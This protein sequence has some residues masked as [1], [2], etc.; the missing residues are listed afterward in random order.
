VT[1]FVIIQLFISTLAFSQLT[2]EA[3]D[4]IPKATPSQKE[5]KAT[6]RFKN[7]G[8]VSITISKIKSTCACL[9]AELKKKIYKPGEKGEIKAELKFGRHKGKFVK[10]IF[11]STIDENGG[12]KLHTLKIGSI[13]PEFARLDRRFHSWKSG[14]KAEAKRYRMTVIHKGPINILKV[15]S[16]NPKWTATFKTI[17]TGREFEIWLT[18]PNTTD[19]SRTA[20]S[21]EVDYPPKKHLVFR[22]VGRVTQPPPPKIEAKGWL[23]KML[24]DDGI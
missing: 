24:K 14:S 8:K 18:P 4:Q 6:Y 1:R 10:S 5:F 2:F 23:E 21:I 17:K 7:T 9:P 19:V 20:L 11:V 15:D 12:R 16:S 3:P 13:I 22:T